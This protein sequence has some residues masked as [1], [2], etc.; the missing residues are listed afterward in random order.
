[1]LGKIVDPTRLAELKT[2][3]FILPPGDAGLQIPK[4]C[5]QQERIMGSPLKFD[6]DL[7]TADADL[8]CGI[9][10]VAENMTGFRGLIS[11]GDLRRQKAIEARKRRGFAFSGR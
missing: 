8:R 2:Q 7:V 9:D 11:V 3:G 1:M 10:E 6:Q 4:A 5:F